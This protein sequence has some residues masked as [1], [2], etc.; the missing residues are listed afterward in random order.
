MNKK[1]K[2]VR[3]DWDEHWLEMAK[4]VSKRSTCL[5]RRFGAVIVNK[6]VVI[7]TGYN[8]APRETPN[9]F[10]LGKCYRKERN[11]PAGSNYEK[12]RSVHAEANAIINAAR[13]GISIKNTELY[14]YGEDA[15]SFEIV[16]G[17]PCKMC[18]RMIINAGIQIVAV[19]EKEGIQKYYVKDWIDEAKLDPFKELDEEGY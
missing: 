9:C 6:N 7:A 18:R 1:E 14:L 16:G 4:V 13:E 8:G 10:D 2:H 19:K 3:P 5:R 15:D 11:I 12:C 17:K